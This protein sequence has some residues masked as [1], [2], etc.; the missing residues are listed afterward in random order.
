M[1][2]FICLADYRPGDWSAMIGYVIIS[3]RKFTINQSNSTYGADVMM[4]RQCLVV[5]WG[6]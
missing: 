4:G 2:N 1:T 5:F 6:R 3:A